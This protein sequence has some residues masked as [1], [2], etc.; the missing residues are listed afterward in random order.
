MPAS[1]NLSAYPPVMMETITALQS[2]REIVLTFSSK[3]EA[4]AAQLRFHGLFHALR[5]NDL[6]H[7]CEGVMAKVVGTTLVLIHAKDDPLSAAI[8]TALTDQGVILP[9][10]R[11]LAAEA[12]ALLSFLQPKSPTS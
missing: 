9:P 11:D 10:E 2:K 4:K 1:K 5:H 8:R 12:E 3:K 7:L 6:G